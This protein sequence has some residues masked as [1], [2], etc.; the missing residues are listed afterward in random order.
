MAM[1]IPY[2]IFLIQWFSNH[3]LCRNAMALSLKRCIESCPSVKTILIAKS[4][5]FIQYLIFPSPTSSSIKPARHFEWWIW[6]QHRSHKA[7]YFYCDITEMMQ[8]NTT[9]RCRWNK[10]RELGKRPVESTRSKG[11]S[12]AVHLFLQPL[13]MPWNSHM[14]LQNG[15]ISIRIMW[16]SEDMNWY[17]WSKELIDPTLIFNAAPHSACL[18]ITKRKNA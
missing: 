16:T 8:R 5:Y 1:R 14:P 2:W 3:G 11:A 7:F 13:H 18:R 17:S 9:S 4:V 6:I 15:E 12:H 10:V